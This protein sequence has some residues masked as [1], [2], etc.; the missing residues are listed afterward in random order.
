MDEPQQN[1]SAQPRISFLLITK[2]DDG[3]M[4]LGGAGGP[5]AAALAVG[6]TRYTRDGI[7]SLLHNM[8]CKPRKAQKVVQALMAAV[9]L[10]AGPMQPP[11][12]QPHVRSLMKIGIGSKCS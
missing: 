8:G 2:K 9:Q 10:K 5:Q 11:Q 6:G 1:V 12:Q 4:G 3:P 7:R